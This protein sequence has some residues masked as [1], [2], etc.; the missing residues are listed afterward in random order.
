MDWVFTIEATLGYMTPSTGK[1]RPSVTVIEAFAQEAPQH[2]R[3]TKMP[4]H[5]LAVT[6]VGIISGV[7]WHMHGS[8]V[9]TVGTVIRTR[10][11]VYGRTLK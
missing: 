1:W 11:S 9:L 2:N 4:D 8:A 10:L 3:R 5:Q 7:A 6:A